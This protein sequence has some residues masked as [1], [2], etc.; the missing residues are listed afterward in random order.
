MDVVESIRVTIRVEGIHTGGETAGADLG[1][2]S[3]V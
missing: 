1:A 3:I 2:S